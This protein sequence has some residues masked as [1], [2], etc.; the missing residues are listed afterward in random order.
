MERVPII[1]YCLQAVPLRTFRFRALEFLARDCVSAARAGSAHTERSPAGVA[2]AGLERSVARPSYVT[3][4]RDTAPVAGPSRAGPHFALL[5]STQ[6]PTTRAPT[7]RGWRFL[8]AA[9]VAAH[10]RFR[11]RGRRRVAADAG[12]AAGAAAD[13]AGAPSAPPSPTLAPKPVG[14]QRPSAHRRVRLP[15]HGDATQRAAA[16]RCVPCAAPPIYHMIY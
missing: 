14:R 4:A 12:A 9:A 16:A 5:S 1:S 15:G 13:A 11:R 3:L 8:D 10:S 7:P 2:A 6:S